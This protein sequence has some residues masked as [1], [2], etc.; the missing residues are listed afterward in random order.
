MNP[1]AVVLLWHFRFSGFEGWGVAVHEQR[2]RA[3]CYLYEGKLDL[4]GASIMVVS[5]SP[6]CKSGASVAA[7]R[8]MCG[9][10]V[11]SLWNTLSQQAVICAQV[12]GKF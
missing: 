10:V 4:A 8:V 6:Q 1:R 2:S 3:G 12:H 11:T 9:R 5:D 7:V